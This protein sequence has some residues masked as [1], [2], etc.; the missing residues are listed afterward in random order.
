[1]TV[2]AVKAGAW[3]LTACLAL[4][5][6]WRHPDAS[7]SLPVPVFQT[8]LP[9]EQP[10]ESMAPATTST[11][12]T[13][14]VDP[15]EMYVDQFIGFGLPAAER[16]M[17]LKI[18]YRES[19]C[20]PT[21]VNPFDTNGGSYGLMQINGFWCKPSKY[22]PRGYLQTK[23]TII[24][25]LDLLDPSANLRSALLIYGANQNWTPWKATSH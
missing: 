9:Y 16:D 11:T 2:W 5:L 22:W 6:V 20:I 7:D 12:S 21:S 13:L 8:Y 24:E 25:C 1:M 19:R 17:A 3:L 15:C 23:G 4:A 18:M 14:P 10:I